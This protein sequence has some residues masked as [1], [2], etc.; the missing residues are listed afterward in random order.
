[1]RAPFAVLAL[2]ILPT[3]L[4]SLA[5]AAPPQAM[6]LNG[7]P[8]ADTKGAIRAIAMDGPGRWGM[9]AVADE[10]TN[11]NDVD[12]IGYNLAA[13]SKG[14][15]AFDGDGIL[16]E[17]AR[18]L[19]VANGTNGGEGQWLVIVNQSAAGAISSTLTI[20]QTNG[21]GPGGNPGRPM[22]Q[23]N[24]NGPINAIDINAAGS[25]VGI[26]TGAA[27][28]NKSIIILRNR[29]F[30]SGP[31]ELFRASPTSSDYQ[32][33]VQFNDIAVSA[34]TT[35]PSGNDPTRATYFIVG[36]RT[37]TTTGIGG[38]AYVFET[39][40]GS[41]PDAPSTTR[42]VRFD[43][44]TPVVR[45]DMSADGEYGLVGTE[46]GQV[47]LV[48]VSAALQ[49]R[50]AQGISNDLVPW[51]GTLGSEIKALRIA[52]FTAELFAVGTE[53]GDVVLYRNDRNPTGSQGAQAV[54]VGSV[55]VTTP[56]CGAARLV[57][58]V[59]SMALSDQGAML[60]VGAHNGILGFEA[61]AHLRYR[62]GPFDPA[63]CI[64]FTG[65]DV[66]SN[67]A[68]GALVDVG[69]D[70][71]RIFVGTGHRVFGYNNFHCLKI[72][73]EGGQARGGQPGQ[74][75][76]WAVTV[77]NEGSL[78]DRVNLN[79]SGPQDPGWQFSLSN[80]SLLLMPG[81]SQVVLLNVTSP[82]GVA[83]GNFT[84]NFLASAERAQGLPAD[85]K[86]PN[87]QATSTL[88]L[89][90]G[91]LRRVEIR[92]PE[93]TLIAS[94]GNPTS[95]P[96][97]IHNGGNAVDRFRVSARIPEPEQNFKSPGS[98]WLIRVDP[99]E[100]E[101]AAGADDIVNLIVTPQ[102]QRGDTA[103]IEITVEAAVPPADGTFVGDVKQV[104]VAVEPS[105]SGDIAL[106]DNRV[107]Q[108]EPGQSIFINFTVKNLGNSRDT[109]QVKNRTEPST[110]PGFRLQLTD[111][112]FELRTQN[113]QKTVRLSVSVQQG[114]Q[115]GESLRI[116]VDLFSEGLQKDN[117]GSDGQVDSQAVS[118]T[119]VP[120][121]K[122][123]LPLAPEP[124]LLAGIVAAALLARRRGA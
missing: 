82:Q 105:Y 65:G 94:A 98:D 108:A 17:G 9:A 64:P 16:N 18:L 1:M 124:L 25:T 45:V 55:S 20:Y 89:D 39:S 77:R 14:W 49:K 73:P 36:A 111:E 90:L 84:L 95:F 61:L 118:L 13:Q 24:A 86:C 57:G 123:G 30:A 26:V 115:P 106:L 29:F 19:A 99:G 100:K 107:F 48:S 28:Q 96:I 58:P 63:W 91:Q 21:A 59:T 35:I 5:E 31:T 81:K 74:R 92:A 51:Q 3:F 53:A 103:I 22:W 34:N 116:L 27:A 110:A 120:K 68:E 60:V 52:D 79:V 76:Q 41:G 32:D 101:V 15:E 102:A 119:V 42:V 44:S 54:Q 109:F 113:Q 71:R 43:T 88:R 56:A 7:Q 50:G 67:A 80:S 12:L 11:L 2:L 62:A 10:P 117:P 122:R 85:A 93:T 66:P 23:Y 112:R 4:A 69:G 38:A 87:N 104:T 121:A 8:T 33:V 83:P 37:T 6:S 47:Y 70:G 40:F 46:G 114:V 72:E 78:F 97:T 75:V